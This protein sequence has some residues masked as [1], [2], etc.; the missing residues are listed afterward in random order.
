MGMLLVGL[1]VD[2]EHGAAGEIPQRDTTKVRRV[3]P[4]ADEVLQGLGLEVTG[5]GS[6][7]AGREA[8]EDLGLLVQVAAVKDVRP[9]LVVEG[10]A[11]NDGRNR[12]TPDVVIELK[13]VD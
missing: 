4:L 1:A 12:I 10:V 6:R 7:G 5:A 3:L 2:G 11:R 13:M 9:F 8:D